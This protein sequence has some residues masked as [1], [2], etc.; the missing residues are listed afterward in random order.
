[1]RTVNYLRISTQTQD[2]ER[3]VDQVLKYNDYKGNTVLIEF[4]E[5]E[6][7]THDERQQLQQLMTYC[8][9]PDN[10]VQQVVIDELSRLG[11]T[12]YV[13]DVIERLNTLKINLHSIKEG[14]NTLNEDLT[15]NANASLLTGIMS[16]LS[17]FELTTIQHRMKTGKKTS[18]KNG[19]WRGGCKVPFGYMLE[20]KRQVKNEVEAQTVRIIFNE[21][22]QGIRISDITKKLNENQIPS[23]TGTTWSDQ[24]IGT[25]LTNSLFCGQ[26]KFKGEVFDLPELE[27][28][29]KEIF[30]QALHQR[31]TTIRPS[32][33]HVYTYKLVTS[34]IKCGICGSNYTP[35]MGRDQKTYNC[36]HMLHIVKGGERCKNYG[37]GI[38]KL[39][40]SVQ[41]IIVDNFSHILLNNLDNSDLDSRIKKY[42]TEI[43]MQ[44]KIVKSSNNEE[45]KLVDLMISNAS[46]SK[47]IFNKKLEE[48]QEKRTKAQKTISTLYINIMELTTLR[49]QKNDLQ[50]LKA[51]INANGINGEILNKIITKIT[52]FPYSDTRKN[53]RHI[54]VVLQCGNDY[55]EFTIS[56]RSKEYN[57]IKR[58][59]SIEIN[60][61]EIS[62]EMPLPY[63]LTKD[64]TNV[65]TS[66]L[67]RLSQDF[68]NDL[69]NGDFDYLID[70]I[71]KN[72]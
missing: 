29:S 40:N 37:I 39:T 57:I 24:A 60:N 3:Q 51:E 12:K 71:V 23:K 10:E 47:E 61:V 38:D 64:N 50:N 16:S 27:I 9:N 68:Y 52:I 43:Q 8:S 2:L 15:I 5:I 65:D 30:K 48:I 67:N 34:K 31:Q 11:R 66:K 41:Q 14:I 42:E 22:L 7:G 53:D 44:E 46:L 70:E 36:L 25:I 55:I 69:E 35:V 58:T 54:R 21:Y 33:H 72:R 59:S 62:L 1:M 56:P 63:N 28:V 20:G 49:Q 6:S 4:K 17:S 32:N 13:L 26:M 19:F 18:V 45:G